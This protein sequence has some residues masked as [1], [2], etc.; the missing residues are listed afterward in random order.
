MRCN[1]YL[2]HIAPLIGA[3]IPSRSRKTLAVLFCPRFRLSA[4]PQPSVRRIRTPCLQ[5]RSK[6]WPSSRS[7]QNPQVVLGGALPRR[8]RH[9][10]F[11][12]CKQDFDVGN[13]GVST[14]STSDGKPSASCHEKAKVRASAFPSNDPSA[15]KRFQSSGFSAGMYIKGMMISVQ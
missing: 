8:K 13:A 11:G 10:V 15:R 6:R 1:S 7:G 9:L 5:R 3:E 14:S 12:K 2:R 4:N